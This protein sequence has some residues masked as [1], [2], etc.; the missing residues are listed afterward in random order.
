MLFR[1]IATQPVPSDLE[2][3]GAITEAQEA[4][5][6]KQDANRL[7]RHHLDGANIDS[8][9]VIAEPIAKVDPLDV[10]LAELLARARGDEQRKQRIFNVSM[11]PILPL[12]LAQAG[13]VAR[14]K[15]SGRT[16]PDYEQYEA[17][18]PHVAESE[19]AR[20]FAGGGSGAPAFKLRK[21][22]M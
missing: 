17:G 3:L 12:D 11:A 4:Q 6:P 22:M 8:L 16:R 14:A 1:A 19:L 15:R 21:C 10:H 9:R 7:S 2:L 20:H 18:Q 5:D 13:D